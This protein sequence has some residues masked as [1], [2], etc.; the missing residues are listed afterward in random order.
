MISP[1]AVQTPDNDNTTVPA[2]FKHFVY[3]AVVI[4]NAASVCSR[5]LQPN[6]GTVA[7][8][9]PAR[10]LVLLYPDRRYPEPAQYIDLPARNLVF[11]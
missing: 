3:H 9:T 7:S 10:L 2:F 11:R 5:S 8:F 4:E 6:S 1:K